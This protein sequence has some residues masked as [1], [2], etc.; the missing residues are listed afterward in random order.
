MNV[1]KK[2]ESVKLM[3]KRDVGNAFYQRLVQKEHKK[4]QTI[5]EKEWYGLGSNSFWHLI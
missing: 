5:E 2:D 4:E 1:K 3:K